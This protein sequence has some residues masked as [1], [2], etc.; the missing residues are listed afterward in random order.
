M[1]LNEKI[2]TYPDYINKK[3]KS[4]EVIKYNSNIYDYNI[5]KVEVK[6]SINKTFLI[7]LLKF[8]DRQWSRTKVLINNDMYYIRKDRIKR[9]KFEL[10]LY[11]NKELLYKNI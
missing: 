4:H 3:I 8:Y 11:K 2:K 6:N 7:N 1:K 5:I 9:G 10:N